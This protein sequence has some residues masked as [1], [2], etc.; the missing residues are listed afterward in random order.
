MQ[1]TSLTS[2]LYRKIEW[3]G[4]VLGVPHWI[5]ENEL[6][7]FKGKEL[8]FGK[9]RVDLDDGSY[10]SFSA[11]VVL[12]C[13]PYTSHEKP[14]KGG[15]RLSHSVTPDLLRTLA[16]DM[17]FKCGVVDIEFGGAK[18]G[19][20]L[21][22]P[23]MHYSRREIHR[24][25]EAVSE[26]LIKEGLIS[27]TYYVPA[28]DVGTNSELMDVIHNKFWE[29]TKGSVV[30]GAP[31]TGRTVENGGLAI[32]EKATALGGLIIFEQ[33]V[34]EGFMPMPSKCPKIIVQGLGQVGGSFVRLAQAR[35]Y[36]IIGVSNISGAVFNPDGIDLDSLPKDPNGEL[37]HLE[38]EHCTSEEIL[39]K[40]CDLLVPAATENVITTK[41]ASRIKAK[42]I[43]EL[44]N[45]PTEEKAEAIL[46][47]RNITVSPDILSNAGGVSASFWEWS[48]SFSHP[49]H[50]IEMEKTEEEIEANLKKQM[51]EA[52][53]Q[54]IEFSKRYNVNL[55]DAAWLKAMHRVS[56]RLEKKHGGRWTPQP[57][58]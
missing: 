43:L 45:H 56:G 51:R 54:V 49:R 2:S 14:Y 15:I 6:L 18:S 28:P 39:L 47:R 41:I 27:P 48:M 57:E 55:R 10:R 40:P 37:S 25:M 19:I 8:N 5:I 42:G 32:R 38:G 22:K 58:A 4:E 21:P 33:L 46:N 7:E 23:A 44:A 34:E 16:I 50:R 9:I 29:I 53:S 35:G 20:V 30:M 31:V 17:T 3:A 26:R 13:N 52:T 1:A 36:K 12:H 11:I 24:I